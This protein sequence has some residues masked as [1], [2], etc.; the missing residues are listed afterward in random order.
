MAIQV[1]PELLVNRIAAGEVIVRPAS[2]VKEL[3][4]NSIDA[5]STRITVEV[6][7]GCRDI[8]VRDD[9]HGI[10]RDDMPFALIRHAT[11]K[12]TEF[13]DLYRLHTRG[14]R[15]E[16]L[17]SI[18]SVSRIQ[19]LSRT[20]NDVA[21]TRVVSDGIGDPRM[22]P[23]GAPAGTEIRVRELFYNTPPRLKFMKIPSAEMQQILQMVLRQALILPHIGFTVSNEKGTLMDLPPDQPW[24]ERI[25]SLLGS[26]TREH[27][28]EVDET[29]HGV[30]I[31]GFVLRPA[32]SRKDRRHQFFYINGRPITSKSL[33][34]ILQE[35]YK[36]IIMV[37]RYPVC[38]LD[39][40]LPE[41][42]VDVNVHPTK[43]EVRFRNESLMNGVFHR[44]VHARLQAA[45]L[46]PNLT[47][48]ETPGS[49]SVV[50][51][52]QPAPAPGPMSRPATQ[53]DI[54]AQLSH[55]NPASSFPFESSAQ[56]IGR[57]SGPV[58]DFSM[59]TGGLSV[60]GPTFESRRTDQEI[61]DIAFANKDLE[62][63]EASFSQDLNF[64]APKSGNDDETQ[65]D[66][67]THHADLD[68]HSCEVRPLKNSIRRLEETR[69]DVLEYALLR[70][71]VLPEP[72]GQLAQCYIIAA[73]GNDLLLIDQHAAHERLLY[74]KFSHKLDNPS[75]QPLLI[76]VSV[77][78][79][80]SALAYI[81]R[82]LPIFEQLGFQVEHFGGAT[83]VINGIPAD[84][85][86]A[87]PAAV[88]GDLLDDFE[89]LGKVEEMD[90]LRDRI[91]TRMACRAAVKAGAKLHHDE[92]RALIR[93]IANAR[94]GFTCPHGRPTMVLLT[95]DQLDKQFKRVV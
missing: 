56:N 75:S 27:L 50:E 20:P 47:F 85:R 69:E 88:I 64:H 66:N 21:G 57:P 70:N 48:E 63:V 87:D 33:S 3:V 52:W 44:I 81:D 8:T 43:E 59:F 7:N 12:I 71:G 80:P 15:G 31:R 9:G 67:S 55:R 10:A 19:V 65:A 25:A 73:C 95:H 62:R 4:E 37:Q 53:G 41:G 82:L 40:E 22:E 60:P 92:M 42:D 26:A 5:G 11:S 38:V 74:L 46:M 30:R 6:A 83:Y 49:E 23:A 13:D 90:I 58:A 76:P 86:N 91:I 77:D 14:F 45:N 51:P 54:I 79:P 24:A 32:A 29:R 84:L 78:V 89:G 39:I 16:A 1:L 2:V 18:A 72:L 34:F 28:L 94:L 17:A 61:A 93:D 68:T 36:G 35:A